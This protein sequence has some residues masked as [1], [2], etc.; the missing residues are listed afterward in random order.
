MLSASLLLFAA[1]VGDAHPC[2][3]HISELTARHYHFL[4]LAAMPA[5]AGLA[6]QLHIYIMM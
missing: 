2:H 4:L 6:Q 5:V 1:L 3:I